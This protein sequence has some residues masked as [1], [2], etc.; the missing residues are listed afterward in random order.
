MPCIVYT[1]LSRTFSETSY[2]MCSHTANYCNFPSLSET[3]MHSSSFYIVYHYC[4][5][6]I[7][8][9]HCHM[10]LQNVMHRTIQVE[11]SA[12]HPTQCILTLP[13]IAIFLLSVRRE[14][15]LPLSICHHCHCL[16]LFCILGYWLVLLCHQ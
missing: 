12:K 11:L 16:Q 4:H 10:Y 3:G 7:S 14:C 15:T 5:F 6:H 8:Y 9:Q 13:T 2:T 1:L